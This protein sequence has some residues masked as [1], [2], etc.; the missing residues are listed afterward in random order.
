MQRDDKV[1]IICIKIMPVLWIYCF[2]YLCYFIPTISLY[3]TQFPRL[4]SVDHTNIT[5][6]PK[7]LPLLC[8]FVSRYNH[9]VIITIFRLSEILLAGHMPLLLDTFIFKFIVQN[10]IDNIKKV[11][12][13]LSFIVT[14]F[15]P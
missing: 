12:S 2:F 11:K 8:I 10:N 6:M 5:S 7:K 1:Q 4:A 3:K 14:E 15:S 13:M 9:T